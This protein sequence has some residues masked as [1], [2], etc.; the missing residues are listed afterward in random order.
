MEQ[1]YFA[2]TADLRVASLFICGIVGSQLNHWPRIS[3]SIV[4]NHCGDA[5]HHRFG[6]WWMIDESVHPALQSVT[7]FITKCDKFYYKLWQ[8]SRVFYSVS[9]HPLQIV[10]NKIIAR[11]YSVS[12][13]HSSRRLLLSSCSVVAFTKCQKLYCRTLFDDVVSCDLAM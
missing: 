8:I 2:R 12:Q 7:N 9:Q 1:V 6:M 4:S 13:T 10:T 5:F 3:D 11:F